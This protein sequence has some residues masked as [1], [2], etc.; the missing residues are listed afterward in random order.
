[1]AITWTASLWERTL[2]QGLEHTC[3]V[4]KW[5][6]TC[7]DTEVQ[8][9]SAYFSFLNSSIVCCDKGESPKPWYKLHISLCL[10]SI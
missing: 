10:V 2:G 9:T 5:L 8:L 6:F 7:S 3:L 1:M 4:S